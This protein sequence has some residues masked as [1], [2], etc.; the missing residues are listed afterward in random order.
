LK[1]V[2][3]SRHTGQEIDDAVTWV[4]NYDGRNTVTVKPILKTGTKTAEISVGDETYNLYCNSYSKATA[5]SA[6]LMSAEDKTKI[7][8]LT[9]A[10]DLSLERS[11]AR[12]SLK[13]GGTE[14]SHVDLGTASAADSG[15]MSA[16]DKRKL[17]ADV[18]AD[19]LSVALNGTR[20]SLNDADGKEQSGFTF[21]YATSTDSKTTDGFMSG[22]DKKKLDGI[23]S[24]STLDLKLSG[25]RLSLLNGDGNEQSG[26]TLPYATNSGSTKV[27]GLMSYTDKG[28]L[29]SII[30]ADTLGVAL[31][32]TRFSL[33][34]SAGKE[35]SGFT[36]PYATS[37][38]SKITDGFMSGTDKAKLDS[39]ISGDDLTLKLTGT[40][41]SLLNDT[42]EVSGVT[43]PYAT[44]SNAGLM[45]ETD[46][47]TLDN[48][49][50]T[51]LPLDGGTMNGTIIANSNTMISSN[52]GGEKRTII[53]IIDGEN[54]KSLGTTAGDWEAF[55]KAFAVKVCKDN[56]G[57]ENPMFICTST[58]SSTGFVM[59]FVYNT[60]NI[61]SNTGLPQYSFG[62]FIN[63]DKR[64]YRFGTQSYNWYSGID[65]TSVGAATSATRLTTARTINGVSFN[66]TSDITIHET[67]SG[68]LTYDIA[69]NNTNYGGTTKYRKIGN[70]V[71]VNVN[72]FTT[73]DSS[74]TQMS[75]IVIPEEYSQLSTSI[76]YVTAYLASGRSCRAFLSGNR[77]ICDKISA[78]YF[79]SDPVNGIHF[80][81][82]IDS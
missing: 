19:T 69:A 47:T 34:D 76:Q 70:F 6:G 50:N 29:D 60:G 63:Y 11:G 41:L 77:L 12:V 55:L 40:R 8:G 10:S 79:D 52:T 23:A 21:P 44:T 42:T 26:V 13:N 80:V 35:Q 18:S 1:T 66:G 49:K 57:I 38:S 30:S 64:I 54:Y 15:L 51:Y 67:D 25:T 2:Y 72:N 16:A 24:A 31:N 75:A 59:Y 73:T 3:I 27:D 78:S 28:K 22:E 33:T 58:Q 9:P 81:Y 32:G 62:I 20:F 5:S 17:D 43:L 48:V 71:E 74:S 7:D 36:F 82:T 37:T 45:T 56:P 14:V 68:W 39:I 4:E 53:K 46:K 65:F 61:S